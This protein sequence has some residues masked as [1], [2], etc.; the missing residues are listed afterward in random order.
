MHKLLR[1]GRNTADLERAVAFYRD[2]LGLHVANANA[3]VPAWTLLPGLCDSPPR[4]ARL[5]IGGQ[6]IEFTEFRDAEPYP[7]HSASNDSWFQHCAIVTSDMRAAYARVMQ[8]GAIPI[9]RGGPQTLPPSTGS[10]VAF[11]F[12]DPDGHPLELIAFPGGAGDPCWQSMHGNGT[13]LGI[14]HSAIGVTDVERS[15]LFYQLLGLDV[16]ARGVNQG[17]EQQR[18]DDLGDVEVDVIAMHAAICTPH[19]ELLGYRQPRGRANA[20]AGLAGIVAD[21]VVWQADN[22]DVLLDALSG[23]DFTDS[24]LASGLIG[25]ATVALLRDPD[26][27]LLVLRDVPE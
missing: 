21:R 25:G 14:D 13:T 17:I 10:V 20:A 18:L 19:L 12:R 23:A 11:K 9:T 4:C 26:R 5:S 16:A 22:V 6:H 3:A 15:I 24:I 27:H 1:I 2:A 8:H 7:A